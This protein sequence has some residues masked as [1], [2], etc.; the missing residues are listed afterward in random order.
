MTM[1]T[2]EAEWCQ[3]LLTDAACT[4]LGQGMIRGERF[5]AVAKNKSKALRSM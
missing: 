4:A 3:R 2:T 5:L 1:V